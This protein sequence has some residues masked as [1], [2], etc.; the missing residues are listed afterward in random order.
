MGRKQMLVDLNEEFSNEFIEKV[1]PLAKNIISTPYTS[2]NS[3]KMVMHL[4]QFDMKVIESK[5]W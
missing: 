2:T 3:S 4:I 1:K 5:K